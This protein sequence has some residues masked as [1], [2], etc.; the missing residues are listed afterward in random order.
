[1]KKLLEI[2]NGAG[3][4]SIVLL[5]LRIGIG[6]M[7]LVHGYPKMQMLFSGDVSQFPGVM[8]LTPTISLALAVFAEVL[9][10]ILILFG[11]ATR[12]A[13]IPLIITMLIAVFY[14]HAADPFA[15][16]ELGLHY[17]MV[18]IALLI[19][20]SGK[21]SLDALLIKQKEQQFQQA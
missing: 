5:I 13:T 8:G 12:L 21:Y 16:Q 7:M 4:V 11:F 2:N 17:L 3:Q 15:S 20:G 9:C 6:L 19:L 14:I 1:M 10:S 18:Y